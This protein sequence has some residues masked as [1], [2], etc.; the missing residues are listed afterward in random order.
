MANESRSLTYYKRCWNCIKAL[1]RY[2]VHCEECGG[3]LY[4][5]DRRA[6][7]PKDGGLWPDEKL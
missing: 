2:Q 7:S 6:G 3:M 1:P 5:F 4:V